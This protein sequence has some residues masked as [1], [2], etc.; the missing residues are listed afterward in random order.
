M[1]CISMYWLLFTCSIKVVLFSLR[2]SFSLMLKNKASHN[3]NTQ[4]EILLNVSVI[5]LL[6]YSQQG[7][8]TSTQE[9]R[10]VHDFSLP[11]FNT[12]STELA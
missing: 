6:S 8:N 4:S 12:Q 11:L 1:Y 3:I 10:T 5:I 7:I 9:Q 2:I